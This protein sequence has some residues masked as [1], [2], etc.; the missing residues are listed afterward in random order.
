MKT[1][2]LV[3]TGLMAISTTA[4][5]GGYVGIAL[6]SEPG[7]NDEVAKD[8]GNPSGKSLRVLGGMRFANNFSIEGALN[9]FGVIASNRGDQT[10]Y[11]ISAAAKFNYPLGDNFEAFGRAGLE[12]TWLDVGDERYN[13]A[14]NG[15]L[16]GAGFE[17]RLDAVLA[18]AAA[19]VDLNFHRVT[20]ENTRDK[21]DMNETV[22]GLGFSIGF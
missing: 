13:W 9:G 4:S 19:F 12:R 7:V 22:W 8:V 11:Q 5:A 1:A 10:A 2:F 6:G 14:G 21:R 3:A 16:L 20:L 15:L 18:N 17:Y